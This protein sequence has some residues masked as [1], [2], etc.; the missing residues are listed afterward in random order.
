VVIIIFYCQIILRTGINLADYTSLFEYLSNFSL[1]HQCT[2]DISVLVYSPRME[3]SLYIHVPFCNH[4]CAYCDFTTY[5]GINYLIPNYTLAVCTELQ[6]LSSQLT[7]K[8]RIGSIYFGG[9]TP[10][11]LPISAYELIINCINDHFEVNNNVEV[12]LE[13]NPGSLS[14]EY[15]AELK[16][17]KF[18]RLSLGMQSSHAPELKFLERQHTFADV[19]LAIEWARKVQ[20]DNYSL[21]LIFGLP[22][23]PFDKWMLSVQRAVDLSPTHL[24]VYGLSI[25]EGTPLKTWVDE[26]KVC[27]PDE[28]AAAEMYEWVRGYLAREGYIHYEIS[29]WAKKA[30]KPDTFMCKHNMQYWRNLPY[31]GIGAGAHGYAFGTRVANHNHPLQYISSFSKINKE[32]L[33]NEQSQKITYPSLPCTN[34][35]NPIDLETE[36]GET[37][38][39][40]LRLLEE[41]ITVGEFSERFGLDMQQI[42]GEQIHKLID[43]GLLEWR[44]KNLERLCLSDR[45]ILLGNQV[46]LE[47]I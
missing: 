38:I 9:G 37:M 46:F 28:D 21:D 23:Q 39:L 31:F 4:R 44:G 17:L 5:A 2:L 14:L 41:G 10:S 26:G 30:A 35:A 22:G 42:Y 36:M 29:N 24:S 20:I 12:S 7:N 47:F 6:L 1:D 8:E 15:L 34:V 32:K 3:Y 40:R 45:G 16:E 27:K 33:N 13:A 43:F 19:I 25:E 18:N 11:L